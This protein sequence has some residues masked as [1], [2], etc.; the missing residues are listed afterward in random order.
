MVSK[1]NVTPFK[2]CR[3]GAGAWNETF[4]L[5]GFLD[6]ALL[7]I[8]SRIAP[9]RVEKAAIKV[10]GGKLYATVVAYNINRWCFLC[11]VPVRRMLK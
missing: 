7:G 5:A 8:V 1:N 6:S 2:R 3:S 11:I 4:E 10:F 9:K